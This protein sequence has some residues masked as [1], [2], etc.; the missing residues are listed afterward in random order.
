MTIPV[1]VIVATKNESHRIEKCLSALQ[2]F[3]EILVVD[4]KSDDETKNIAQKMGATIFDFQWN[5]EY[6]KKRQWILETLPIKNDFI[7]FVDADEV[8][9]DDL[10]DEIFALDFSADGYFVT[11]RYRWNEKILRYGL[12]NKK[13]SLFHREKFFFPDIQDESEKNMGEIEGH[14]QPLPK[15]KDAKLKTLRTSLLHDAQEGWGERHKRYAQWENFMN[16]KALWPKDPIVWRER[17]K[18]FMRSNPLRPEIMFMHSYI[19]KLGFL[20]GSAGFDFA[21]SRWRYYQMIRVLSCAN[22]NLE[23]MSAER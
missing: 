23:K 19:F 9:S 2:K 4:S 10:I 12:R 13:L 7:F 15:H 11:G 3:S 14:Y 18:I 1:S 6:P 8:L 20:D 17:L 5:G 21:L 16:E 22:K